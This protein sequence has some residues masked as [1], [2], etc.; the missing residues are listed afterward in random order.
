MI[1]YLPVREAFGRWPRLDELAGLV[2]AV[3]R[4]ELWDAWYGNDGPSLGSNRLVFGS[5]SGSAIATTWSA[6][7]D[8][9]REAPGTLVFEGEV[10]L[11]GI[12]LHIV[13]D[14]AVESLISSIWGIDAL[15][16]F[17]V[18]RLPPPPQ[19]GEPLQR[20]REMPKTVSYS[21]WPRFLGPEIAAPASRGA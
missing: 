13:E 2:V 4:D 11:G 20:P 5:W 16:R 15:T 9:G 18:S 21:L 3:E 6:S 1:Q 12:T 14:E 7:W 8:R 10:S 19:Y 17:D